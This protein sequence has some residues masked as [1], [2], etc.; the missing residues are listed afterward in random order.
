MPACRT[1]LP[2]AGERESVRIC[3]RVVDRF[4]VTDEPALPSG[5]FW[6]IADAAASLKVSV[7]FDAFCVPVLGPT[8]ES[9][10]D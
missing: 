2:G 7:T 9:R 1:G 8:L 4:V 5:V 6:G 3:T 10:H